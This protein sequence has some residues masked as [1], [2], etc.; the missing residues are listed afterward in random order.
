MICDSAPGH[1]VTSACDIAVVVINPRLN[2]LGDEGGDQ[3]GE[4]FGTR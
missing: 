4:L 2:L 3:I 1:V